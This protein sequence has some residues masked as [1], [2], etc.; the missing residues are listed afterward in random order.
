MTDHAYIKAVRKA[1][2]LR[3]DAFALRLG[4]TPTAVYRW[5]D[6]TRKLTKP[7]RMLIEREFP[8]EHTAAIRPRRRKADA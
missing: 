4:V 3:K 6:K 1:A 5:E 7:M 2:G 8:S